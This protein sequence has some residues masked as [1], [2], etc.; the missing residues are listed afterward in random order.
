MPDNVYADSAPADS[1]N[2][3]GKKFNDGGTQTFS[4][5]GGFPTRNDPNYFDDENTKGRK[6][7]PG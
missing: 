7:K 6:G 2:K 4:T 1:I 5:G 3:T